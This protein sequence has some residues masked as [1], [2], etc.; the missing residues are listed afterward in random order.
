MIWKSCLTALKI[1]PY[2]SSKRP[3]LSVPP[4]VYVF[5]EPY[6]HIN[7]TLSTKMSERY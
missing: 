4:I 7:T 2:S 1:T 3:A 5:P 6:V